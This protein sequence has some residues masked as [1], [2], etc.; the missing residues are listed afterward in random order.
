MQASHRL[1]ENKMVVLLGGAGLLGRAFAA[2]LCTHGATV[3]IADLQLAQAE[4]ACAATGQDR[5]AAGQLP[6]PEMVDITSKTSLRELIARVTLSLGRIDAMVNCAYPR[7]SNYGR[8]AEV[9]EYEDFC[10]NVAKH[11]GG[12]FL[13]MQQFAEHFR[14]QGHGH[15]I[16]IA[17]IYG[18]VTPRFEIYE[19][20]HMT[21]PVEY[22][23]IKAGLLQLSRYFM[24]YYKGSAVRFNCISPGGI[25]DRQPD[26]FVSRYNAFAQSK[27]M[28]AP[29]D[30]TGT[31][32]YLI[33]DLSQFVNGQ[34]IVVDD[35]WST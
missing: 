3:V 27:G 9:V 16:N 14:Q 28:L 31:L 29:S 32:T 21:M 20:T 22:A 1:L 11:L 24:R 17:S 5:R 12:Y 34:N 25:R 10:D 2:E 26:S 8:K 7:N 4:L 6:L 19:G 15:V 33:S 23:A 18:S 13:A 30:V 35:G